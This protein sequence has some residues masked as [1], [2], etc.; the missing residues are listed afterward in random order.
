M[1]EPATMPQKATAPLRAIAEHGP[2]AMWVLDVETVRLIDVN[3]N[4]VELSGYPRDRMIGATP[5]ELSAPLQDGGRPVVGY[6]RELIGRVLAGEKLIAPWTI[7][8]SDGREIPCE[9]RAIQLISAGRRLICGSLTD[10]SQRIRAEREL[11]YRTSFENLI[12]RLSNGMIVLTHEQVDAGIH[13]ALAQIGQFAQVDRS[14]VFLFDSHG[15]RVSCT[16]E[17]CAPGI[18]PEIQRLQNLRVADFDWVERQL[19]RDEVV[20]VPRVADVPD[21]AAAER[22][23]WQIE[24]IQSILLVPMRFGSEVT[25]Y[26]G[27]DSVR[28]EKTWPDDIIALLRIFGEMV[29]NALERKRAEL[30][31]TRQREALERSNAEL[32]Q[33]A[34]LASHD[35]QEPLRAIS[36]FSAL[37]SKQYSGRLDSTA[38]EYIRYIVA[39][40]GRMHHMIS[41]LL[42]YS[43]I[44]AHARPFEPCDLNLVLDL[45]LANLRASITELQACIEHAPLPRVMGDPSQLMQLFQNLIGNALKFHG[46]EPPRVSI[47]A[48]AEGAGWT[49]RIRDNGIGIAAAERERVFQLFRRLHDDDQYPGTGIGL[50]AC[51]RI[52]ERHRGMIWIEDHDGPGSCFCVSLP[53]AAGKA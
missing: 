18:E 21:E 45:A 46:A 24:G 17:W 13:E 52:V 14:Y 4:F 28:S 49:L 12:M 16:H 37:L 33:F 10:V 8:R 23:E 40:A 1:S 31:L 44:D 20:H 51:R 11:A 34:Y 38:D 32:Q 41:D 30:Q 39:A 5:M 19:F 35:L 50:A 25:G 3:D 27:F 7:L 47:S 22:K 9:L 42:E 29:S 53:A 6:T 36:G 48:A 15:S 43:R 2:D 26:T